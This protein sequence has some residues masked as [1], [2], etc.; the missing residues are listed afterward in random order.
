M[1]RLSVIILIGV[2]F[3][4]AEYDAESVK[5]AAIDDIIGKYYAYDPFLLPSRKG[6]FEDYVQEERPAEVRYEEKPAYHQKSTEKP[7]PVKEAFSYESIPATQYEVRENPGTS[8]R[9]RD[10]VYVRARFEEHVPYLPKRPSYYE[11]IETFRGDNNGYRSRHYPERVVPSLRLREEKNIDP[12]FVENTQ[13][14]EF[15]PFVEKPSPLKKNVRLLVREEAQLTRASWPYGSATD[16]FFADRPKNTR[17]ASTRS[18]RFLQEPDA[19]SRGNL[20]NN[21]RDV[22]SKVICPVINVLG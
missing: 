19:F 4:F 3:V 6:R 14:E 1:S 18:A 9:Y 8:Q 15:Y 21:G 13:Q 7:P 12:G 5:R 17:G 22:A 16:V 2:A 10:N 11:S 20:L